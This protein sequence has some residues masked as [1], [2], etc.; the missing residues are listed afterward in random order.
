MALAVL[1]RLPVSS[2]L[3]LS[4]YR[5][6]H[7]PLVFV[8]LLAV[9]A[10]SRI[11]L[12]APKHMGTLL[13]G[14]LVWMSVSALLSPYQ[15]SSMLHLLRYVEYG[16]IAAILFVV[17]RNAWDDSHWIHFSWVML[18]AAVLSGGTILT[19][20]FGVTRCFL[21]YTSE[22]PYVRHMGI[23]GE[24]NYGAGKLCILLPF[25]LF[26]AERYARDRR[27]SMLLL[28]AGSLLVVLTAIFISGS[29]MAGLIA[30]L[31]LTVFL[32]RQVR[33][34]RRL[35]GVLAVVV[36]SVVLGT[37]VLVP[38]RAHLGE[39][40]D[41]VT[42]RYGVLLSYLRTGREEYGY[43][44]ETSIRERIDVLAAGVRMAC[45][46]PIWGVG[47][48]GFPVAIGN[49]DPRYASVYSHNTCLSVFAELGAFGFVL[50]A[51]L[52]T[53]ILRSIRRLGCCGPAHRDGLPTYLMLAYISQLL[54]FLFLHDLDSKY[55]WTLF[56]PLALYA[57]SL[58]RAQRRRAA[59][60]VLGGMDHEGRP[61][62]SDI[63]GDSHP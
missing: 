13:A 9:L 56:L 26:L 23:L 46:R 24:A 1:D 38:L 52:C 3:A 16:V 57:D 60:A 4:W 47:P 35:R 41:Y 49:Y 45:A 43:V 22:R 12:P 19:D 42:G 34:W 39:A 31:I 27:W 37:A 7:A 5:V 53:Q 51:L 32:V 50:F 21:L 15:P 36:L 33:S 63:E 54:V 44:R 28:V 11:R 59:Q 48:G 29:R 17:L 58:P 14:F 6:L 2:S 25:L 20:Y 40:V 62:V 8:L 10:R 18:L 61:E 30:V 55:L